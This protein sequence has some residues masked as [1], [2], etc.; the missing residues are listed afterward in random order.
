MTL[1]LKD[2][3]Y[4]DW[5]TLAITRTHLAVAEGPA[6]GLDVVGA[7]PA[8]DRL[9]SH[10]RLLDCRGKLVTKAFGCGHHHIYSTLARGMP[11]PA[12]APAEF[13]EVLEYIWWHIDKR[14]DLPMIEAS[15]LAAAIHCAKSGVGFV[16]DHHA[17]PFAVEGS[18]AVIAEAFERVGIGHLLCY[19]ISDRDGEGPR[20]AGLAET[21]AYLA[22]GNKGHVGLHASFTAGDDLLARA[23]ELAHRHG[24]G[25][26]VHVAEDVADQKDALARY[27]KR[28]IERFADAGVLDLP[29]SIL[30]HCIH[31]SERERRL[32]ADSGLWVVQNVESNQNNK[33]GVTGYAHIAERTLLGTDG[34]HSDMLRSAKAAFLVGQTTEGIGLDTVY[35]RF[36][37]VHRYL[38]A[39]GAEGDGENNLVIL[40]YDAPTEVTAD[41]FLGHFVYGIDARHVESVVA[42]GRLIVEDRRVTR[43]DEAE[44]LAFAREMGRRL[45]EKL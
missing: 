8:A 43:V 32:L 16:I 34:M 28:V 15:A 36:R 1:Y 17:S 24:T 38:D 21:D 2:A 18:L 30:A 41:N 44:V 13:T 29:K 35:G 19:E 6:G 23:V 37:N 11:A 9:E 45:W 27:G 26:H 39:F 33:V 12:R 10:D 40:D 31:L 25:L 22:A 3:N 14:L 5:R 7:L 4:V 20:E 42:Q